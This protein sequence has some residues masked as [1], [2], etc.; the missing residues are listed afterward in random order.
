MLSQL[1]L[2]ALPGLQ[3]KIETLTVTSVRNVKKTRSSVNSSSVKSLL[4]K[5]QKERCH[6]PVSPPGGRA[7]RPTP[8]PSP[9][10]AGLRSRQQN[11]GDVVPPCFCLAPTAY[12]SDAGARWV[13]FWRC[14]MLGAGSDY[15]IGCANQA[16]MVPAT[17]SSGTVTYVC[18][19]RP[20][21]WQNTV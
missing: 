19:L 12:Y 13:N 17:N 8:K 5:R 1:Q 20:A 7:G 14:V 10:S 4:L 21:T 16:C 6:M 11:N 18:M 3:R 9:I 2:A 15:G